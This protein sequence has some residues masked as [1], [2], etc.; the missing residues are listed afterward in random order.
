MNHVPVQLHEQ[1]VTACDPTMRTVEGIGTVLF[2]LGIFLPGAHS[3]MM[4]G[5][6]FMAIGFAL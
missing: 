4:L 6:A 1:E 5:L 2:L 3:L